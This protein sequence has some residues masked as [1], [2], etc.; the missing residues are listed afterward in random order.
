MKSF[1]RFICPAVTCF[2]AFKSK[3]AW[4]RHLRADHADLNLDI[5]HDTIVDVPATSLLPIQHDHELRSPSPA[6]SQARLSP[7]PMPA[8]DDVDFLD[9]PM[10]DTVQEYSS[11]IS[12]QA[13][14]ERLDNSSF[15][16]SEAQFDSSGGNIDFHPFI[17]GN[18]SLFSFGFRVF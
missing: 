7:D 5:R 17:N 3:S 1:Q 12:S 11:S 8:Q 15:P 14:P 9:F 2:R 6:M 13:D 4:T 16:D 10:P 18:L